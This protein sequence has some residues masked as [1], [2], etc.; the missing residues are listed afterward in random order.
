MSTEG[1]SHFLMVLG[2]HD[3][4]GVVEHADEK[5]REV[6]SQVIRTGKKGKVSV[7]IEVSPNGDS[8]TAV[9]IN[10]KL[11][12]SAPQI[13][14]A[15]SFFFRNENNDLTRT[16]PRGEEANLLRMMKD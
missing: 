14:F 7:T 12:A 13:A 15:E 6:V 2:H 4:G 10:A 5:L 16:P 9:K 8:G 3:G 11:T 1:N